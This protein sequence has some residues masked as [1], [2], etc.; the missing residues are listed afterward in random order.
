MEEKREKWLS[1]CALVTVILALGATLSTL[2]VG[3]FS[4]RSI[5]RQ[6]QASNQ[7]AYYQAKSIKGYLY[8]LQKEKLETDLR[9]LGATA[10]PDLVEDLRKR[11]ASYDKKLKTYEQEKAD[12]K[13]S[14]ESLEAERDQS[15]KHSQAFGFAVVLLQLAIL[16]SSIAA[17]MKKPSVWV[18]GLVLGVA[19]GICF[20]NGFW[21]F[22]GFL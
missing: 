8:E 12:I 6:T 9:L 13:K 2:R 3:S 19:G 11:I 22:I 18:M 10:S 16:L 20:A 5:L 15:A 21:L 7:W 1:Y 17:L 14:A 4:N